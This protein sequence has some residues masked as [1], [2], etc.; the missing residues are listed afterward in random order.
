MGAVTYDL[1]ALLRDVA[2]ILLLLGNFSLFVL[3][4]AGRD[5]SNRAIVRTGCLLVI[6]LVGALTDA[7]GIFLS[8]WP[9]VVMIA[10]TIGFWALL[11][12]A[13]QRAY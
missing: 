13:K 6:G 9:A 10:L 7:R 11:R 8:R 4:I 1:I 3:T 5:L 2:A 12:R